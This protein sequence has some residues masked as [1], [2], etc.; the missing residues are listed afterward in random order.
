[1]ESE[2]VIEA[3]IKAVAFNRWARQFPDLVPFTT[4]E[5]TASV[6]D[7]SDAKAAIAAFIEAVRKPTDAMIEAGEDVLV[8]HGCNPL[9]GDPEAV[10]QAMLDALMQEGK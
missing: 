2:K 1:M 4:G 9:A 10:W 7:E 3:A 5:I 8:E 6:H